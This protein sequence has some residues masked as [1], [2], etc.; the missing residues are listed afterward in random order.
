MIRRLFVV[1]VC[2]VAA[3][4][5]LLAASPDFQRD[6]RPILAK[7][8]LKCHGPDEHG[9]Q[10]GLRLDLREAALRPA[11]SGERAVVPG[12]V[13]ASEMLRR[14]TSA[15]DGTRMPP[16]HAGPA[17]NA[18]QVDVLS[19]WIAG[20]AEYTNHWAF[21]PVRRP[22]PPAVKSSAWVRNPIDSFVLAKLEAAGLTPAAEADRQTLVRR[23]YLDLIGLPP[24]PEQAAEFV[25]DSDPAA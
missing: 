15:D 19:R 13:A 1:V 14:V 24:T 22:A 23:L 21:E 4:A 2:W 16:A 7:H 18:A 10:G 9:R 12:D 3:P 20:G 11:E 5:A 6:V 8:C 25:A 17:L